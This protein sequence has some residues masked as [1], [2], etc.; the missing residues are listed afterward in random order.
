MTSTQELIIINFAAYMNGTNGE[1]NPSAHF[2]IYKAIKEVDDS[3]TQA[4]TTEALDELVSL[5]FMSVSGGNYQLTALGEE[6]KEDLEK[7]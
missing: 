4:Q 7:N 1:G 5:G 6:A 3:I 2:E